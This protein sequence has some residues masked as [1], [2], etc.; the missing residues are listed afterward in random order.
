MRIGSV[1]L[2]C[3]IAIAPAHG[4]DKV[5]RDDPAYLRANHAGVEHVTVPGSVED[6]FVAIRNGVSHCYVDRKNPLLWP[7]TVGIIAQG[8]VKRRIKVELSDDKTWGYVMYGVKAFWYAP[9]FQ[10]DVRA[11]E[12]GVEV[13]FYYD[14][15]NKLQR[16]AF[17]NAKAWLDGKPDTCTNAH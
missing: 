12:V 17:A 10:F 4:V 15:D 9:A 3:V 16:S 6:A 5:A 14:N 13:T 8:S 11:T 7:N 2:L 1:L